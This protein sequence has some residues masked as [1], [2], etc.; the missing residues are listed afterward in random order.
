[1][2]AIDLF[3]PFVLRFFPVLFLFLFWFL[4]WQLAAS[5]IQTNS[6]CVSSW[7]FSAILRG[8]AVEVSKNYI[9]SAEFAILKLF[10]FLPNFLVFFFSGKRWM[11]IPHFR[12]LVRPW[13]RK[14]EGRDRKRKR[15]LPA[16]P[17]KNFFSI[18]L[19]LLPVVICQSSARWHLQK[20]TSFLPSLYLLGG[21]NHRL[22]IAVC[23]Q[24]KPRSHTLFPP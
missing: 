1:M 19:G 14:E 10:L 8:P 16:H 24:T 13:D 21:R 11:S 20:K 17:R 3:S 7:A 2:G 9:F 15:S 5:D 23:L 6:K 12:S 22:I 18:F 4:F